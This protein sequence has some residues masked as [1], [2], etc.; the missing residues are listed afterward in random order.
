MRPLTQSLPDSMFWSP[1]QLLWGQA[2]LSGGSGPQWRWRKGLE[3]GQQP[4]LSIPW[5]ICDLVWT[6]C[7]SS[8]LWPLA[9]RCQAGP[10]LD[11]V[12]AADTSDTH[13]HCRCR[14]T[15]NSAA[16]G[17][18]EWSFLPEDLEDCWQE[19]SFACHLWLQRKELGPVGGNL[20]HF[21][22]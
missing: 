22:S 13:A 21:G 4:Y 12:A 16:E 9:G 17:H 14:G 1:R 6:S 15:Q 20:N 19:G 18:A 3:T 5:D 2:E 7:R 10:F 8:H 11:T